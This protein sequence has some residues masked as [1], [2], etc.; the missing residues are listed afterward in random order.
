MD[1]AAITQ[2]AIQLPLVAAFIWFSLESQKRFN[3]TLDKRD[4]A[5]TDRNNKVCQSLDSLA[6]QIAYLTNK[7]IEH[8]NKVGDRIRDA[9]EDLKVTFE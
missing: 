5:F 3:E 1:A 2:I 6:T 7:M 8:D 9:V 4:I